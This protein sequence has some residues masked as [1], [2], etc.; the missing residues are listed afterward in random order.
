VEAR[1]V[2]RASMLKRARRLGIGPWEWIG[3]AASCV[4]C[5]FLMREIVGVEGDHQMLRGAV[6]Q[7][8]IQLAALEKQKA[9]EKKK[10]AYLQSEKG[11]DQ[12]LAERGYLKPGDRILLFPVEPQAGEE[13]TP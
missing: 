1:R 13:S 4:V 5:V 12:I 6:H 9:E 2:P 8:E 10:L 7:K 3:L 11:R